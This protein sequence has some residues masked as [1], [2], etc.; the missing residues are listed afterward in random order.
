MLALYLVTISA[1][2]AIIAYRTYGAFLIPAP[3]AP[4]PEAAV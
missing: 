1:L 2:V 3:S 4:M